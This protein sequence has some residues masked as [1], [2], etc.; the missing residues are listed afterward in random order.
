MTVTRNENT[1]L[2]IFIAKGVLVAFWRSTVKLCISRC[3]QNEV[4]GRSRVGDIVYRQR[5]VH[6]GYA[7]CAAWGESNVKR[8]GNRTHCPAG[9]VTE[10]S[11]E[12]KEG[13][14]SKSKRVARCAATCRKRR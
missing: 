7:R 1:G 11:I 6:S 2:A 9:A 14:L 3:R 12:L 10:P 5:D 4:T 8:T 13:R